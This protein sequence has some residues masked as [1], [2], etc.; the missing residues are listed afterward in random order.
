[1]TRSV[2]LSEAKDLEQGRARNGKNSN[3]RQG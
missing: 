3:D 2:I 1:M